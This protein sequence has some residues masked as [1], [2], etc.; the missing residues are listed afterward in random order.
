MSLNH[1]AYFEFDIIINS[2]GQN[3]I[4]ISVL[5]P[6]PPS[7]AHPYP[8]RHACSGTRNNSKGADH[9]QCTIILLHLL[10]KI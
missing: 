8:L 6:P 5:P 1:I 9:M 2:N 4:T 10:S 7:D 3:N